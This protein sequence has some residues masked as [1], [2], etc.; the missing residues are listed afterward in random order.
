MT[1]TAPGVRGRGLAESRDRS[2]VTSAR[3]Y[4]VSDAP[5]TV[6][7][8]LGLIWLL[9]GGL[10]FQSFMYGKG[11]VAML[12][13]MVAGQPGWVHDS[14]LWGAQ[15]MQHNQVFWN[16]LFALTQVVIGLGL[17]YRPTVKPALVLSFFWAPIV[18]WFGEAFGMLFM[19]MASPLTGAPGAVIL[20]ALIG[21]SA[22]PNGRPGGLLGA[23]GTRLAWGGVWALMAWLW[24][25]APSSSAN[26]TS[27][28]IQ[29]APSGMSWLSTIQNWAT[30]ATKGDGLAIALVFAALSLAIA[31]AVVANWHPKE[32]L[33]LSI[34][35][36]LAYWVFG[37]GFGGIFQGGATDPNAGPLFILFA[38]AVYTLPQ[39]Q[40]KRA[41]QPARKR[42]K[43]QRA[44]T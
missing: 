14:V 35:I 38:Y 39:A 11:F 29:A 19:T 21:A 12:T 23:R 34:A 18:W 30:T 32:F 44:T 13:S 2:I 16:T 27:G 3:A 5:R 25:E 40:A 9:D 20:Y 36:S 43:A 4:F 15:T 41:P 17:L 22:W 37:Q 6:Q 24:L 8:V 10:Q 1:T 26:A 28:A 31:V 7:T 42:L 33:W